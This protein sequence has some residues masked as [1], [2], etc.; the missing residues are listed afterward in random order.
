MNKEKS[1]SDLLLNLE[2]C[3][4][5]YFVYYRKTCL[6]GKSFQRSIEIVEHLNVAKSRLGETGATRQ[7]FT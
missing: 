6:L 2:R 7:Q 4:N 5:A 1:L 3:K